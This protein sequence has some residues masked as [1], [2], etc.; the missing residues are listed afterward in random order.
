MKKIIIAGTF[1]AIALLGGSQQAFAETT[2]TTTTSNAAMLAK[3]Q[4]LM[5]LIADLQSKLAAVQGEVQELTKDLGLGAKDDDVL[6]AQ[7][8][9]ASDPTLFGV[10]PT[11]YFGPM[12]E[13]AIKKFQDRY[14]LEVTG[15]LDAPTREVMKELRKERKEGRVPDGLVKS[16]EVK[17]RIKDRLRT[18]WQNCD[19]EKK[20]RASVCEKV[21][22][23]DNSKDDSDDDTASSTKATREEATDAVR[24]AAAAVVTYAEEVDDMEDDSTVSDDE[25]DDAR[26][27]LKDARKKLADARRSL[28]K[29]EYGDAVEKA[30]SAIEKINGDDDSDDDD[31]DED[32]DDEDEDD[33]DD[34]EDDD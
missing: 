33:D 31:D 11:G 28:A 3:I 10:K 27:V 16:D 30:E 32:D 15:K 29:R 13:S 23:D 20:F 2:Q 17:E 21:K 19:F 14:G 26:D 8:I 6:K 7:E 5:K 25:L 12:T 9:L 4:D 1:C 18:K 34:E 24:E 22:N